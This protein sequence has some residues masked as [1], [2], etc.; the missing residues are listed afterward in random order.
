MSKSKVVWGYTF[1]RE[2]GFHGAYPTKHAAFDAALEERDRYTDVVWVAS[3]KYRKASDYF[4]GVDMF[5]SELTSMAWDRV[6]EMVED[7]ISPTQAQVD[8]LELRFKKVLDEWADEHGLH[9]TFWEPDESTE[10][11]IDCDDMTGG[12]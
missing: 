6:D 9:P 10:E 7:W 5:L 3:G 8:D 12:D 2:E 4:P 1:Y 11:A